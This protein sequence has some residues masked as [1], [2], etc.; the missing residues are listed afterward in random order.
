MVFDKYDVALFSDPVIV[1]FDY[2]S[3]L[4]ATRRALCCIDLSR[5]LTFSLL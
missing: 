1:F 4:G 5:F 2:V 3:S